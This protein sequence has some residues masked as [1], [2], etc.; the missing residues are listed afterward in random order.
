VSAKKSLQT[1]R[2]G[3]P[4]YR[5]VA[6]REKRGPVKTYELDERSDCEGQDPARGKLARAMTMPYVV[7]WIAEGGEAGT[8]VV[9]TRGGKI[10]LPKKR[11]NGG[12]QH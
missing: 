12:D 6:L 10:T 2:D 1:R 3:D 4:S 5:E 9:D 8:P 7:L 11:G